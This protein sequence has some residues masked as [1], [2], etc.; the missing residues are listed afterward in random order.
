[1]RSESR[2]DRVQLFVD[3]GGTNTRLALNSGDFLAPRVV[4]ATA[5]YASLRDALVE[6]CGEREL[7]PQHVYIGVAAPVTRGRAKLT[8][9]AMIVDEAELRRSW[10]DADIRMLNDV[11]ALAYGLCDLSAAK[12]APLRPG[13]SDAKAARVVI[14]P[15]TGLGAAV[16]IPGGDAV[17][18]TEFGQVTAAPLA[19]RHLAIFRVLMDRHGRLATELLLSGPGLAKIHAAIAAPDDDKGAF[20]AEAETAEILQRARSTPNGG[21]A[22]AVAVFGELLGSFCG[23]AALAYK[24]RGGVFLAGSLINALADLIDR[25]AFGAAF[26][27]KGGVMAEFVAP[28]PVEILTDP[29]PVLSGLF[30]YARLRR[31]QAGIGA[32]RA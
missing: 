3:V 21:E 1:M 29:E 27:N 6:F 16:V 18:A 7:S 25:D 11:E 24:A 8:N 13:V 20:D 5:D 15:G 2:A 14:A 19:A 23:D 26:G 30:A 9:A 31:R 12:I 32:R 28:I 22:S 4:K 10:P 17:M